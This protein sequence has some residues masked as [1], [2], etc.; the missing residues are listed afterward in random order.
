MEVSRR[1]SCDRRIWTGSARRG[2]IPL[3]L[4]FGVAAADIAALLCGISPE[5]FVVMGPVNTLHVVPGPC[6]SEL[7]VRPLA[8][9]DR[10]PCLSIAGTMIEKTYDRNFAGTLSLWDWMFGTYHMP[11]GA[12]PQSYGID[13][14][15]MPE[16]L[17]AQIVYPLTPDAST[18]IGAAGMAEP[19]A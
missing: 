19:T 12:L 1:A 14:R 7:D 18:D 3:N 10:Q 11:A 2:F 4:A 8:L 5:I 17:W 6:Q 15:N 16:G 9:C 13:D